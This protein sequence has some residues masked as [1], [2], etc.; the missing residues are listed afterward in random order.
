MSVMLG[1]VVAM[2]GFL[3]AHLS[4]AG[5]KFAGR[6]GG[7][8][9]C[10][11]APATASSDLGH[12][13]HGHHADAGLVQLI[14]GRAPLGGGG[15]V[16]LRLD[17]LE[18]GFDDA[19]DDG[20]QRVRAHADEPHLALLLGLALRLHQ[21]VGDQ[22]RGVLA[23]EQPHVHVVGVELLEAGIDLA[24]GYPLRS[25]DRTWWK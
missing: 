25:S 23:V 10:G 21:F 3:M 9:A 14:E 24:P 17:H 22:L 6:A 19:I 2:M 20:R 12:H 8:G 4:A 1:T 7:G 11:G 16:V 18:L 5:A 13:L 15:E